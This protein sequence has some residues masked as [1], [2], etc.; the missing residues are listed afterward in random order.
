MFAYCNNSPVISV[1][2][3]GSVVETIFDIVSLGLS[4]AEVAAN[5]AN[6]W[7]WIGLAGDIVDLVPC[8][9]GVGELVRGVRAVSGT[10]EVVDKVVNGAQTAKKTV[11]ALKDLEKSTGS[12]MI[13]FKNGYNYAGKGG[14]DRMIT[15]AKQHALKGETEVAAMMWKPAVNNAEAFIDEYHLQLYRGVHSMSKN[16]EDFMTYNKI[17]S[18]GKNMVVG[19]S[20]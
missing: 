17:W 4:I 2:D 9:T 5:P 15:S 6:P 18:P 8:V 16:G 12:Y 19:N 20:K 1:D 7:A 11:G 3:T 14:I 10:I 13:F